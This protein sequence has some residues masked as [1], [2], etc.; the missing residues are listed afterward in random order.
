M[1]HHNNKLTLPIKGMHCRSCELLIEEKLSTVKGV[2]RCEVDYRRGRAEIHFGGHRPKDRD[3]EQAVS[4]A[5][6]SVGEPDEVHWFSRNP[7]TYKALGKTV[8]YVLVGYW[9]LKSLGFTNLNL[10]IASNPSGFGVV[11]L[12]GLV[13]GF[14]SCM[15]LIGGLTLGIS[16]KH[17]EKHPEATPAQKFKPHLYFNLGRIGGYALLGGILGS[18]GSVFQFSSST[19]GLLTLAVGAVMLVIGLQLIEISPRINAWKFTLP[20]GLAKLVGANKHQTEY[21]HKNSMTMGALTFFLPC[22][23]TQAMQ[24]Y[25][26]S[27]GDFTKGALIMGLFALG[28][29]PG[30]L[31]IGGLS[32]VFR[33]STAKKFFKFAGVVVIFLALFNFSNGLNLTGWDWKGGTAQAQSAKK[34]PNVKLVDGVQVVK[35]KEVANGYSPSRF[36]VQKGI[37]VRWEIDAQA[38]Y[39]CA[40]SLVVSKLNVRKNLTAGKNVIKFTPKATGKIPFSCS[41]GMYTGAFYVVDEK[42]KGPSADDDD[43]SVGSGSVGGRGGAA[44]LPSGGGCGGGGGGCGGGC[45]GGARPSIN[46][47]SPTAAQA[48]PDSGEQV[49]TTTYRQGTDIQ[50]NAFTVKAGEPVRFEIDAQD[51]GFGCMSTIMVPGLYN[52]P[53]LLRAGEKI[54]MKFTPSEPGDYKITCAMGM[55]RGLIKVE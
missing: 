14:S 35:M 1:T 11:L 47:G 42:G 16:A 28:T 17:A 55:A 13:A 34:D 19:L 2:K 43:S 41:M 45:G 4:E 6:Y 24:L 26:V 51:N 52:Q 49:I 10:N 50:P 3:I 44:A 25:A 22:G 7:E 40:A 30:L 31:S 23:F 54:V 12:V 20:K 9:I 46:A 48:D 18:V 53:E 36:T 38:P 39:S 37:P 8:L 5:G 33:G 27:T 32:S 21:S 15:A 29:A